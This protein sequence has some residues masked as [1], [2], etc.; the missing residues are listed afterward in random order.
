MKP[1]QIIRDFECN[2]KLIANA[3]N[4]FRNDNLLH[5]KSNPLLV[6]LHPES[7][8]YCRRNSTH[9]G[10]FP[11][12]ELF[13]RIRWKIH[14][15]IPIFLSSFNLMIVSSSQSGRYLARLQRNLSVY[16]EI[17]VLRNYLKLKISS[18]GSGGGSK[19]TMPSRPSKN[20]S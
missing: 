12:A 14:F 17:I 9:S 5:E 19:G 13:S 20:K 7:F 2:L 15:L 4:C 18:S 6:K 16:T 10:N 11:E 8:C 3:W 1:F